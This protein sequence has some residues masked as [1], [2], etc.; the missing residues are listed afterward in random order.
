[1]AKM[2]DYYRFGAFAAAAVDVIKFNRIFCFRH[3]ISRHVSGSLLVP[4]AGYEP[5][6]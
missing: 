4:V 6:I 5:L 2:K 3:F 1:M